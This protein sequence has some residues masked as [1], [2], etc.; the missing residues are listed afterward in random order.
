MTQTSNRIALYGRLPAPPRSRLIRPNTPYI[1]GVHDFSTGMGDTPPPSQIGDWA[2]RTRHAYGWPSFSGRPPALPHEVRTR[3][4]W[5]YGGPYGMRGLG[6]STAQVAQQVGALTGTVAPVI[7]GVAA[8]VGSILGVTATAAVPIIGAA[9]AGVTMGIVAMINSGCG[10]TCIQTSEYANKAT[11]LM[12][13]NLGAYLDLPMPHTQ[14]QQQAALAN[15][16]AIWN[17]L[18]QV[19]GSPAMGN[20]GVRCIQNQQPGSCPLKVS[21]FGWKQN[22]DGSWT[23]LKNG[24][25]GSGSNCWNYFSGFRDPIANDPT[26]VAGADLV[27]AA[28][29]STS[30]PSVGGPSA[31]PS[32][33]GGTTLLSPGSGISGSENWLLIGGLALAAIALSGGLG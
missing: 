23:Y 22:P 31:I 7:P 8:S 19:C 13:Q 5:L 3:S 15:F 30:S 32:G 9:I 4:P 25:S 17:W 27:T 29:R 24:P 21:D 14:A 16:D 33:T 11:S 26:V 12:A 20:A 18:Q 1:P 6:Q 10:Q 28:G 2:S